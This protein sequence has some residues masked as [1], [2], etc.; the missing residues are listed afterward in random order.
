MAT[1]SNDGITNLV[2]YALADNTRGTFTGNT[3]SFIKRGAPFGT[4]ITYTI[5]VT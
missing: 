3:L 1:Q 5:E 4:D 2:E